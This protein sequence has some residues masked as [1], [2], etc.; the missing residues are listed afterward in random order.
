MIW[1]EHSWAEEMKNVDDLEGIMESVKTWNREMRRDGKICEICGK[2]FKARGINN[3][4][5]HRKVK[6]EKKEK[7][8]SI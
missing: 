1:R 8:E 2:T 6:A 4:M 3:H 5:R 7:I